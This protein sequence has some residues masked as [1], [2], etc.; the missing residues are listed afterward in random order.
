MDPWPLGSLGLQDTTAEALSMP[1]SACDVGH[2]AAF[3]MVVK[4]Q[5][6]INVAII[7]HHGP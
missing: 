1:N 5:F 6:I 4:W 2:G 7:D 3:A